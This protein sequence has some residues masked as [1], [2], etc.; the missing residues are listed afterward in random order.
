MHELMAKRLSQ[1]GHPTRLCIYR[2]LTQAGETGLPVGE[3]QQSLSIPGST[4]SHHISRLVN[5][6]LIEQRRHGCTLFCQPITTTLNE[7]IDYLSAEC[8]ANHCKLKKSP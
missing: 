6:G 5:V 1:L 4:L 2:L 8:C 7:V 3:I